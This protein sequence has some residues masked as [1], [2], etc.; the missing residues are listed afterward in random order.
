MTRNDSLILL[1]VVALVG[2][3]SSS[4]AQGLLLASKVPAGTPGVDPSIIRAWA[5]VNAVAIAIGLAG[6]YR[7]LRLGAVR[8][9]L[10]L[11]FLLL[12]SLT[13]SFDRVTMGWPWQ[14][15]AGIRV[16]RL[17]VGVNAVGALLLT[18]YLACAGRGVEKF[19]GMSSDDLSIEP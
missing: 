8:N 9:P 17:G 13:L 19:R 5:A 3:T 14:F 15:H 2:A 7:A 10:V 12:Y 6:G 4:A 16:G 1:A 18:L 11:I